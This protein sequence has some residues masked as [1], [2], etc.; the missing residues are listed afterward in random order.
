MAVKAKSKTKSAKNKNLSKAITSEDRLSE[1]LAETEKELD[2]LQ[3]KIE[4]LEKQ[5]EKLQ[6]LK[7][8][9]QKLI[10][11]KLSIKAILDNFHGEVPPVSTESI[12]TLPITVPRTGQTP[13][14][15]A[16]PVTPRIKEKAITLP[17]GVFIPENAFEAVDTILKRKQSVNY[18]MYRA[19]VYKGGRATTEDIRD[20]LVENQVALPG[21]GQLFD[22]IS[23]SELASRINYLIRKGVLSSPGR[24]LY[25]TVHGWK[26]SF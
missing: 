9:K 10:T 17:E 8:E 25:Q 26:N 1:M 14:T 5:L 20:Y 12:T 2:V 7:Q 15:L 13:Q 11:L 18:E 23:L 19:V 3:P 16:V 6:S 22:T 24:G 4:R 21:T